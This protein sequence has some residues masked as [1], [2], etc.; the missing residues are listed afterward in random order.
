M[1]QQNKSGK[2]DS[3]ILLSSVFLIIFSI[4][5]SLHQIYFFQTTQS[6]SQKMI[7]FS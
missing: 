5:P 4:N 6:F 7:T 3:I 1:K 2:N